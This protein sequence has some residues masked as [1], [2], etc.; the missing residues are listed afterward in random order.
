[1]DFNRFLREKDRTVRT[2]IGVGFVLALSFLLYLN[3]PPLERTLNFLENGAYDFQIRHNYKPLPPNTPITIVDL[4]DRSLTIEGR[5][6]W[7]RKKLAT[8]VS[9]LFERGAT[10]VAFDMTFPDEE[11]NA[12]DELIQQDPTLR[13]SLE[14][15]RESFDY[16]AIL[17]KNLEQGNAVLGFIFKKEG[18]SSGLLPPPLITTSDPKILIPEL[19]TYLGNI[20]VLQKAAK[21][22]GFINSSPDRD[23]ILRVSPLLLKHG[24]GLYPS[25]GLEAARL[26]L[27]DQKID[28]VFSGDLLEGVQLEKTWIPTDPWG[29]VL[30]P[31]RGPPYTFPFLSATDVLSGQASAEQLKGKLV[32][33][34]SSATAIGDLV[35]TAISPVFSGVEVH[36]AIASA[37]IDG[38]FPYKPIWGR[39]FTLLLV[40]GLGVLL[41]CLLPHLRILASLLLSLSIPFVLVAINHLIWVQYGIVLPIFFA[42]FVLLI[43]FVIDLIGAYV[44]EGRRRLA[45]KQIFGQYVPSDY[46]DLMLA[47]GG[48]FAMQGETKELTVLFADIRNFSSISEQMSATEIK[49]LLNRFLTPMTQ[50]IFE[51]KGTIDKYVGD[52]IMAFWGAPLE[53]PKNAHDAVVAA[54]LMQ[55]KL[56]ELNKTF[57]AEKKPEIHIGI[58]INTGQMNVGDMGSKFRRAYTVLGDAVNLASRLE[59][60]SK[61]YHVKIIVGEETY[62]QTANQFAYRKLDRVRVKGRAG[63]SD[64]YEPLCKLEECPEELKS[65]LALHNQAIE[66]YLQQK[67]DAATKLFEQLRDLEREEKE[68]YEMYL[69]R[70][71]LYRNSPPGPD[72]DGVFILESKS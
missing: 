5:W 2:L 58:G 54:L 70:L 4:D 9:N 63:S 35:S 1:M 56:N 48:D 6:P 23:G 28:L 27:L 46:I 13:S 34:G 30:I 14:E 43:L 45:L 3:P 17:A 65:I 50:I 12:I 25:I 7:S 32:F 53:D 47:K 51:Q 49:D 24:T 61:L 60:I 71:K 59:G 69:E 67:W 55:A 10:V 11:Q 33:V 52:L 39:G 66:A 18:Q 29:R 38:S 22:G 26:F 19:P 42:I 21:Y 68:L 40:L 41:A 62:K 31:F 37:I 57:A 16:N 72:W 64:I 44:F 36:A 8:L 20:E 15:K